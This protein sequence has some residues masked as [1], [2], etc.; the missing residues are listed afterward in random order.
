LWGGPETLVVVSSDLSHY[1][2]SETARRLDARTSAAIEAFRGEDIAETDACGAVP[3]RGLLQ[4]ARRR[5][6]LARVLD[7]RNS[8]DTAGPQDH[9][10]GYGAYAFEPPF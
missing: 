5:G 7:V 4:V 6:L 8:G 9:V 3:V 1:H 10:V 2:D